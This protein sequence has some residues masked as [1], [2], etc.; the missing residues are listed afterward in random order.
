MMVTDFCSASIL[1]I[2]SCFTHIHTLSNERFPQIIQGKSWHRDLIRISRSSRAI[3][4]SLSVPC[5][6]TNEERP[7]K[8]FDHRRAINGSHAFKPFSC[9]TEATNDIKIIN[10]RL[11]SQLTF[12]LPLS[13]RNSRKLFASIFARVHSRRRRL[14]QQ[15]VA[16]TRRLPFHG[17][18]YVSSVFVLLTKLH[19]NAKIQWD[20]NSTNSKMST[21]VSGNKVYLDRFV[22]IDKNLRGFRQRN[23]RRLCKRVKRQ[24]LAREQRREDDAS[25][26]KQIN[27]LFQNVRT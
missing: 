27:L 18:R 24:R 19:E 4:R 17:R 1:N 15:S 25:G 12:L 2:V 14:Q 3:R 9:G 13:R 5:P 22:K 10:L 16:F 6:V 11:S 7:T 8:R 23:G 20:I 26:K 21:S